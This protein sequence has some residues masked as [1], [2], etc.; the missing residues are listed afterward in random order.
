MTP[1]ELLSGL[2]RTIEAREEALRELMFT[3]RASKPD[4]T[5]AGVNRLRDALRAAEV[6]A[7]TLVELMG[8]RKRRATPCPK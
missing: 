8:R 5:I 7:E 2:D 6:E 4:F 1:A 3:I